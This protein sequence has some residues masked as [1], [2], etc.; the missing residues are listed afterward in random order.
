MYINRKIFIGSFGYAALTSIGLSPKDTILIMLVIP[1]LMTITYILLPS[2]EYAQT[3]AHQEIINDSEQPVF[4]GT[5]SN[6]NTVGESSANLITSAELEPNRYYTNRSLGQEIIVKIKLIA[7]L[8][9]Y[10]LPL[11]LVF[12]AEYF[13]NQGLFELLYF[14]DSFIKDHSLQY[15]FV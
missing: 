6:I 7:S 4:T 2:I 11:F 10:M 15:R 5:S 14:K 3:R 13:I 12:F 9:K 1:V 8:T